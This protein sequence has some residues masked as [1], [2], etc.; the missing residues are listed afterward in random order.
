MGFKKG[1][2]GNPKGRPKKGTS[3]MEQLVKA[4]RKEG[5]RRGKP[6]WDRVAEV[7]WDDAKVMIAVTR[8]ML[9][10]KTEVDVGLTE[11]LAKALIEAKQRLKEKTHGLSRETKEGEKG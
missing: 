7:S 11:G 6:F 5:V 1:Q 3:V 4:L 10:D 2:S 9:P 8:K